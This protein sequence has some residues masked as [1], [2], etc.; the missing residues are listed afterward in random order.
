MNVLVR[1][2]KNIR[3]ISSSY[4]N[5]IL[6]IVRFVCVLCGKLTSTSRCHENRSIKA[7]LRP[8]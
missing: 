2:I 7:S 4:R 8:R 5:F 1:I 3:A 6:E